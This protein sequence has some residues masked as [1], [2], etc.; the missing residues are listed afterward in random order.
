MKRHTRL[1]RHPSAVIAD[2]GV[3]ACI[4]NFDG[5]H[6]GHQKLLSKIVEF[7]SK[8]RGVKTMLISLYPHPAL[9][10]G[11]AP[12]L[13]YITS[14]A[15][16]T[17]ILSK[18]GIDYFYLI[19][20]TKAFSKIPAEQFVDEILFKKL[21]VR[22]LAT[23]E[24]ARVGAGGRGDTDFLKRAFA[25]AG[26]E[27]ETVDA[28]TLDGVRVSSRRVREAVLSA[29]MPLAHEFM[30]RRF[31]LT[32]R[33]IRGEQRG[34]TLGFATA[35]LAA[36]RRALRPPNGVY[37]VFAD[38]GGA[39]YRGVTNIGTRPTLAG[40]DISIE[41]HLIGYAGGDFYGRK[42]HLDFVQFIRDEQ[43]FPSLEELKA[44]IARDVSTAQKILDDERI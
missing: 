17:E 5:V 24:D 1:I 37:A 44:Q 31:R 23:G 29:N 39:A 30:G 42:L 7:S 19:H 34:K 26:R 4:G 8:H 33:V 14:P 16:K 6:I 36:N 32:G 40:R 41:T 10:L 35:N 22:Y 38:I 21:N 3:A 13:P 9:V 20:F 11:R 12:E 25:A 28:V 18:I 27:I 2:N 15:R 43:K